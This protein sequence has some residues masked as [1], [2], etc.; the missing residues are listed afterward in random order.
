MNVAETTPAP[1][2][3][4]INADR[5]LTYFV[6][7]VGIL[8]AQRFTAP[9]LSA[10]VCLVPLAIAMVAWTQARLRNL[11]I[12]VALLASVDYGDVVYQETPALVRYLIY[13]LSF[14]VLLTEW[15]VSRAGLLAYTAWSILL[16]AMTASSI[17]HIDLYT[18]TRDG[19]TLV[20]IFLVLV[21]NVKEVRERMIDMRH[22]N[23]FVLGLLFAECV[24]IWLFFDFSDGH[25]LNY[26]SLKSVIVFSSLYYLVQ[27]RKALSALLILATL[28]VLIHYA[29]RAIFLSYIAVVLAMLGRSLLQSKGKIKA[30]AVFGLVAG[31]IGAIVQVETENLESTRVTRPLTLLLSSGDDLAAFFYAIDPVRYVEHELFFGRGTVRILTGDGLGSGLIDVEGAFGFV[32]FDSGAFS[33]RELIE[34]KFYRLHDAWIYFGLRF[35]LLA[36]VLIYSLLIR[37][38]LRRPCDRALLGGLVFVV[39][40]CATFS[41]SGLILTGILGVQ[42]R[43]ASVAPYGAARQERA[44]WGG[45]GV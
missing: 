32:P 26:Q 3:K 8:S 37:E 16:L 5:V 12:L 20:L 38:I 28:F 34:G 15:R 41:I 36:V 13:V 35:G 45:R 24:N 42:L 17:E 29:T 10:Y 2:G 39:L 27:G 14:T 44:T 30:L 6:S 21:V 25:Y 11:M 19:I 40:N 1:I 33:D 31:M 4:T 43:M 22:L 7:A 18:L 23:A 9:D